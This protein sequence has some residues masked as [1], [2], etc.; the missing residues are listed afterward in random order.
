MAAIKTT[1]D[2]FAELDDRFGGDHARDTQ[3]GAVRDPGRSG[4]RGRQVLP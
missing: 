4:R 1:A 3:V 2:M